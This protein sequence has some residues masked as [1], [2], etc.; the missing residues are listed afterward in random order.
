MATE[1]RSK[2]PSLGAGGVRS[3]EVE[4]G[5]ITGVFG[6]T[7]EVRLQLHHR[8]SDLLDDGLDVV[9]VAPDGER[10]AATVSARSGAGQRVIGRIH[11]LDVREE[12]YELSGFKLVVPRATLPPPDP[13]EYYLDE[14]V[15]MEVHEGGRPVGRVVEI[16][17]HGPVEV[18]ELDGERYLP[19]TRDHI[20][21]IDHQA[22][23][24]HA[25]EGAVAV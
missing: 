21:R 12:V 22:R 11:G 13:D 16:H 14:V 4:L 20:E 5:E 8:E 23:V 2:L 25:R 17:L 9:L 3:D 10:F 19:S 1:T 7:G 6:V 18:L 24:I 15:G